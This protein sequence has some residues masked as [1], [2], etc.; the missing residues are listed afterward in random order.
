LCGHRE[1]R[2]A[3]FS[4]HLFNGVRRAR[5]RGGRPAVHA[6]APG[7]HGHRCHG[8]RVPRGRAGGPFPGGLARECGSRR[9]PWT[10]GH[11]TAPSLTGHRPGRSASG[12]VPAAW[13]VP[14]SREL[15][16][17]VAGQRLPQRTRG[18]GWTTGRRKPKPGRPSRTTHL[19]PGRDGQR[20]C[21]PTRSTPQRGQDLSG[22][23]SLMGL[24][25][26]G[27]RGKPHPM[28]RPAFR[29]AAPIPDGCASSPPSEP[30]AG[31]QCQAHRVHP[32]Q[33]T[34]ARG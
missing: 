33:P 19:V 29:A 23:R 31:H 7:L 30:H 34:A 1:R 28:P 14:C 11:V 2:T 6:Q 24:I 18:R 3:S 5:G 9:Q 13:V 17:T 10:T 12:V 8:R 22:D 26:S 32:G 25:G 21:T 20:C 15:V 16:G 4:R 27:R